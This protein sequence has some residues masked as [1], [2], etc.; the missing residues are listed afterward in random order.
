MMSR[1]IL[2]SQTAENQ[3]QFTEIRDQ[4]TSQVAKQA[5]IPNY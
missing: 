3:M 5:V 2:V 4:V 1:I